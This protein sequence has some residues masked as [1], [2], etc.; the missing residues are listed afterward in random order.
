VAELSADDQDEAMRSVLRTLSA[1]ALATNLA[2]ATTLADALDAAAAGSLRED[3]RAAAEHAAHQLMGS[4]GTFGSRYASQLAGGLERFFETALAS[5]HPAP[6]DLAR[7]RE[8]LELL[9]A[10][11]GG[12]GHQDEG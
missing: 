11:L 5:G 4:A 9:Q 1:S 10:E 3:G 8:Q 7:A 2:R 12:E 6:A